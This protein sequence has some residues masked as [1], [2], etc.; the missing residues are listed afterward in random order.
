MQCFVFPLFF[1]HWFHLGLELVFQGCSI[2]WGWVIFSALNLWHCYFPFELISGILGYWIFGCRLFMFKHLVWILPF[3]VLQIVI[4][5]Y[6]YCFECCFYINQ[7]PFSIF[8]S[9]LAA[10]RYL[11]PNSAIANGTT[12]LF[13]SLLASLAWAVGLRK[14]KR[15]FFFFRVSSPKRRWESQAFRSRPWRSGADHGNW[16]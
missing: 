14:C 5:P 12:Y 4:E 6:C 13:H 8:S 1:F 10:S 11:W 3:F 2:F 7:A 16:G 15:F 9:Y